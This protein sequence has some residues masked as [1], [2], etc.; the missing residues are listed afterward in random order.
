MNLRRRNTGRDR[1]SR[2]ALSSWRSYWPGAEV[3]DDEDLVLDD[4][5]AG[6]A[7]ANESEARDVAAASDLGR[8]ASAAE[9]AGP[10]VARRD[11]AKR[12]FSEFAKPWRAATTALQASWPGAPIEFEDDDDDPVL[13]GADGVIGQLSQASSELVVEADRLAPVVGLPAEAADNI[14]DALFDGATQASE[15][16]K[17]ELGRGEVLAVGVPTEAEAAEDADDQSDADDTVASRSGRDEAPRPKL[18]RS[19]GNPLRVPLVG[20]RHAAGIAHSVYAALADPIVHADEDA[21]E[22]RAARARLVGQVAGSTALALVLIYAI[23]PVREYM[24]QRAQTDRQNERLDV[25][26]DA[27][28][29]DEQYIEWLKSDEGIERLAREQ[30]YVYPDEESYTLLPAPEEE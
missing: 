24:D 2:S 15:A 5:A 27:I 13:D 21:R 8:S 20:V 22:R 6:D 10:A 11:R 1:S 7:V 30:G 12:V 14:D 19:L 18:R 17:G 23:F 4:P 25:L 29:Q 9:L 26:T 28:E 16:S 3:E